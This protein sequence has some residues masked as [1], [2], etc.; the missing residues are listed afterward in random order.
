MQGGWKN[1]NSKNIKN[2]GINQFV[3]KELFYMPSDF[4]TLSFKE[5]EEYW[6]NYYQEK[7]LEKITESYNAY[8]K[9]SRSTSK[10]IPI[11]SFIAEAI[12]FKLGDSFI[13]KADGYKINLEK[14]ESKEQ[15][16]EGKY[17]NKNV[18]ISVSKNGKTLGSIGVKFICGNYAQN[19]N[20]YFEGMLGETINLRI[21]NQPYSQLIILPE[22]VPYYDKKNVCK[23]LEYVQSH[24]IEKYMKLNSENIKMYHRPD[25]M[26]IFLVDTGNKEYLETLINKA[27]KVNKINEDFIN[28]IHISFSDIENNEHFTDNVKDFLNK[29]SNINDFLNAFTALIIA[30]SYGK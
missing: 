2:Y 23:N 20:N 8:L 7:F 3:V 26:S 11:H 10:I 27:E 24:H 13:V 28:E 5:K 15:K 4:E 16:V 12:Q 25:I 1:I 29:H 30:N 6:N 9:N 22:F 19:A 21:N 17:Y 18:D 14:S